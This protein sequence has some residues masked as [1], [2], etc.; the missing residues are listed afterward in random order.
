M[1]YHIT[2]LQAWQQA[3]IIGTY[4][5]DSLVYEGFIHASK[6]EQTQATLQRY[7]ST[8]TNLVILAIN[9]AKCTTEIKYEMADSVGE[10]FPH[11]YGKLNIDAVSAVYSV[12][13]DDKGNNTFLI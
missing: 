8:Q 3:L 5:H 1:I 13:K 2:T 11:I 4:T 6:L 10:N 9:L 12:F 7:Y